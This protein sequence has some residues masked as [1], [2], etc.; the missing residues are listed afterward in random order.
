MNAKKLRKLH[1][2]MK[3]TFDNQV[4][5]KLREVR[6]YI[7]P[8]LGCFEGESRQD[9]TGDKRAQK[10]IMSTAQLA[11]RTLATGFMSGLTPPAQKWFRWLP[12]DSSKTE[13]SG[14][15][16][17]FSDVERT[18]Y[19]VLAQ[20]NF[21]DVMGAA[22]TELGPFGLFDVLMSEDDE[23]VV[24]F[25]HFPI[26]SFYWSLNSRGRV[27]TVCWS[28][29]FTARQIKEKYGENKMSSK[30][31]SLYEKNSNEIVTCYHFV[32]PRKDYNIDA[33]DNKNLPFASYVIESSAPDDEGFLEESGYEEFPHLCAHWFQYGQDVY[34]PTCPGID[35]IPDILQL[36][37]QAKAMIK[38]AHLTL[39]PPMKV[40][41]GYSGRL[42]LMPSAQNQVDV[43]DPASYG[44]LYQINPAV[45]G[46]IKQWTDEVVVPTIEAHF[47]KDIFRM[48]TGENRS[49]VTATE[50]IER[51]QEKMLEM[52]P[53]VQRLQNTVL[54][55]LLSRLFSILF[56]KNLLPEP[57][58]AIQGDV[59]NIEYLSLLAQAQKSADRNSIM[60][61]VEFAGSVANV[62]PEIMDKLDLDQA[63]DEMA[64]NLGTPS[65]VVASD[66]QV[67]MVRE[68][69]L[70]AQQAMQQM[71][72]MQAGLQAGKTAGEIKTT[73]DSLS[74]QAAKIAGI[75]SDQ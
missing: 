75:G 48:F 21:Y 62:Y 7:L 64:Q 59:L 54:D 55:P 69:R 20:S 66:D 73:P 19:Q 58:E 63:V 8:E 1:S 16:K 51:R 25:T 53:V 38:G 24:R 50:I 67:A 40:P 26:G 70:K 35:T 36:Q 29:N 68:Q 41:S 52:G 4:G 57:P 72:T 31:K 42:N 32:M 2:Q 39:F 27:D 43:S 5:S 6:D 14:V 3:S 37:Q 33:V 9:G 61:I 10:V 45:F 28:V 49:G 46:P 60:G 12:S 22:Y 30:C 11:N 17:W 74:G 34:S 44:P 65:G 71:Q 23:D 15:S 18:M 47:F 56:R 13:L